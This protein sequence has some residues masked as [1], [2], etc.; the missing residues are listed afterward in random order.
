MATITLEIPPNLEK[1]LQSRAAKEGRD[2]GAVAMDI[3]ATALMHESKDMDARD[4]TH[5]QRWQALEKWVAALPKVDVTLDVSR[6]SIYEGC[7]E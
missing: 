1:K 3:V 2:I 4:L 5:E 7:G 6:D